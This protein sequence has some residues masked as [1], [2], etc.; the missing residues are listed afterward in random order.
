VQL[1][2]SLSIS[3][4]SFIL[5]RSTAGNGQSI[6]CNTF[7]FV[8]GLVPIGDSLNSS[9]WVTVLHS[10][11]TQFE[12]YETFNDMLVPAVRAQVT[13]GKTP[14]EKISAISQLGHFIIIAI[15]SVNL[16]NTVV[17]KY[18]YELKNGS[19]NAVLDSALLYW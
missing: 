18:A 1:V 11:Q 4:S 3:Y 13:P 19:C 15:R 10:I 9:A 8:L 5:C 2:T 12:L 7:D 17:S 16:Q 14:S 6:W